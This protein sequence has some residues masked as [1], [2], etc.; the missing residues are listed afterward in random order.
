MHTLGHNTKLAKIDIRDEYH[1]VLIHPEDR[2]FIGIKWHNLVY[3]DCQLPFG[4]ASAPA[5]FCAIASTLEW[6]L[7]QQGVRASIHYIDDLLLFGAPHSRE[8]QDALS[9]ML[10]TCAELGAF[11][12]RRKKLKAPQQS[13][14]PCHVRVPACSPNSGF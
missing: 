10:A 8:C 6:I 7:C 13:C 1:I 5:N 9:T 4:L 14:L 11:H 2:L 12:W 3:V